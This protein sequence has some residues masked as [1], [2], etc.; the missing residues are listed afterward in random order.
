MARPR[1][2]DSIPADVLEEAYQALDGPE[3]ATAVWRRLLQRF[4]ISRRL[5]QDLALEHRQR[6]AAELLRQLTP[7][8]RALAPQWVQA[9]ERLVCL[10]VWCQIRQ[11]PKHGG[12]PDSRIDQ[13]ASLRVKQL[14]PEAR[15]SPSSIR[16]WRRRYAD[17]MHLDQPAR[18]VAALLGLKLASGPQT[19]D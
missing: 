7:A 13:L 18:A 15:C 10:S 11:L 3:K 4:P 6:R 16:G 19:T 9:V 12:L 8:L 2:T 14:W 5:W 1:A 17:V